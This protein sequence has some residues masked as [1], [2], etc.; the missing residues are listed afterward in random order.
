MGEKQLGGASELGFDDSLRAM[1]I[2]AAG[3]RGG[4]TRL[5]GDCCRSAQATRSASQLVQCA[6]ERGRWLVA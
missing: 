3:A 6:C 1:R 2:R 4:D 5:V